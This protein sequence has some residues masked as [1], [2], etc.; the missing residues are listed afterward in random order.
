MGDT[1]TWT[2]DDFYAVNATIN[3]TRGSYMQLMLLKTYLG[4]GFGYQN[5]RKFK[6]IRILRLEIQCI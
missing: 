1:I 5:I 3:V 4:S 6:R 2:N